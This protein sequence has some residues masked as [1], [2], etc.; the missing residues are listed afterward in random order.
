MYIYISLAL[1]DV[2]NL[3]IDQKKVIHDSLAKRMSFSIVVN[4]IV[5]VIVDRSDVP[6]SVG[7]MLILWEG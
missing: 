2:V 5:I 6:K 7:A 3:L 1:G 4:V